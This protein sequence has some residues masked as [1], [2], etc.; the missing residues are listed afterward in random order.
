MR[1][2]LSS[3]AL[4]VVIAA[5]AAVN[6]MS[7]RRAADD[8]R[9]AILDAESEVGTS[10]AAKIAR[11]I[12][13][14]SG[15]KRLLIKENAVSSVLSRLEAAYLHSLCGNAEQMNVCLS[16]ALFA[17]DEWE[18]GETLSFCRLL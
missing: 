2:F 17:L 14:A 11:C 5:L 10:G 8:V 16:E 7:V 18:S 15:G 12:E 3:I 1:G 13:L 6:G 9:A 4:L